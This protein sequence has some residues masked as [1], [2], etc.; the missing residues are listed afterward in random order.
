[1]AEQIYKALERRSMSGENIPNCFGVVSWLKKIASGHL[2]AYYATEF[3]IQ[4]NTFYLLGKSVMNMGVQ[5]ILLYAPLLGKHYM[6]G[7]H[8]CIANDGWLYP[9]QVD[10]LSR[11]GDPYCCSKCLVLCT[12]SRINCLTSFLN[13]CSLTCSSTFQFV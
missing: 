13:Q 5:G 12:F 4:C 10:Q 1:M 9:G 11:M 7:G 3:G 2:A 6:A 8:F